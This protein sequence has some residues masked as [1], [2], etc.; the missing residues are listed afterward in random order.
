MNKNILIILLFNS[1]NSEY[2]ICYPNGDILIN[3]N[4]CSM[5]II[6]YKKRNY[7]LFN[8]VYVMQNFP[9]MKEKTINA[10]FD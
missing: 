10:D 6:K 8:S 9:C 3:E 1:T 7:V 2:I 5:Y 4:C